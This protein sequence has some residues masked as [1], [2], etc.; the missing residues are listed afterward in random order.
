MF[1]IIYG[2]NFLKS[3]KK[4]SE[5][6]QIKLAD[7]LYILRDEPF[8]SR[9]HT[10]NLS[11]QLFGLLSFRITRDWRVIFQFNGVEIINLLRVAHCKDIYRK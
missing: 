7:L 3:V 1:Q 11:G 8:D 10:K 5:K 2:V 4:L 9:L 6:T